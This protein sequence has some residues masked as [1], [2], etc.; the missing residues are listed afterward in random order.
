M[1]LTLA[2]RI[3]RRGDIVSGEVA[4]EAVLV[5]PAA[6][7]V[8][9]LNEVGSKIWSLADGSLT[10]REMAASVSSDY[11]VALEEAAAD[12]LAFAQELLRAGLVDKARHSLSVE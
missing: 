8:Q 2:D 7:Q 3:V 9:M 11:D 4:G 10:L 5:L 1:H 6:A 12:T